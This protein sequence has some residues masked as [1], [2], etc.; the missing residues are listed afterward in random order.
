MTPVTLRQLR[1]RLADCDL[2]IYADI[3]SNTVLAHDS[4]LSHPQ[5]QLD[6]ICAVARAFL[7]AP[8]LASHDLTSE[9]VL[10]TPTTTRVFLRAHA[11]PN[12]ALICVCGPKVDVEQ[13]MREMNAA[14]LE[15]APELSS[16]VV[17]LR[18]VNSK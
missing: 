5:E 3:A 11:D 13:V 12:E 16:N 2:L 18:E 10:Q 17:T 6:S 15:A 1:K 14:L 7:S 4:R 8:R 9:S